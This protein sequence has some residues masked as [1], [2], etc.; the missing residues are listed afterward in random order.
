M[1]ALLPARLVLVLVPEADQPPGA[2]PHALPADEHEQQAV[3]QNQ[4]QHRA[5]NKF[6][7]AKKRQNALSSCM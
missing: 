1:N 6:R 7:Y 5:V 3:A 4:R 2:K